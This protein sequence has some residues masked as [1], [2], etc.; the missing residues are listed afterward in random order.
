MVRLGV[1]LVCCAA[2]AACGK[3][4]DEAAV[5]GV[6]A[7]YGEAVARKDYQRICDELIVKRLAEKGAEVGLPC[8]LAFKQGLDAVRKP[9]LTV[10]RIT[11]D[12]DKATAE[13]ATAAQGQ[14]PSRDRMGL[15][16]TAD[17]WRISAVSDAPAPKKQR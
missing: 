10:G 8:E 3:G 2:L 9:R 16:K 11:V 4:D 17:G 15:V 6:V 7:G 13:V 14:P 12:G 5:R 1:L